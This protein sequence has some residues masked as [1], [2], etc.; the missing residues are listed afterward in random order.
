MLGTVQE[1]EVS[2]EE[3][4]DH[5]CLVESEHQDM[6][7]QMCSGDVEVCKMDTLEPLY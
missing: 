1:L 4:M 7:D 5:V 6:G 3:E 2:S